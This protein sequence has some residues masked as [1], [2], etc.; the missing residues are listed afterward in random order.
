MTA[1]EILALLRE[2]AT[3]LH[4]RANVKVDTIRRVGESDETADE[5][6]IRAS[7]QADWEAAKVLSALIEEIER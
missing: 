1:E 5:R 7:A 4:Q 3:E 6:K 2:R